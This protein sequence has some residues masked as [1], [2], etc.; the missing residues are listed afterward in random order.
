[1]EN[2]IK[3]TILCRNKMK[4]VISLLT[5]I[6]VLITSCSSQ[7]SLDKVSLQSKYKNIT[8]DELN[9]QLKNKDFVLVDVHIPEQKHINGT[10]AFIP[11]DDI[12][13]QLDK[14]PNDKNSKIVLYCRTGRMSEIAAEKLAQKGYTNIYNVVGGI[15]EWVRKGYDQK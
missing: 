4:R 14:L 5:V 3:S 11:F 15:V 9:E 12:E 10:N 2:Y 1:M 13:N 6:L 7:N 8:V